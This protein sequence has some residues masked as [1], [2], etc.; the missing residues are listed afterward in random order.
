MS[1]VSASQSFRVAPRWTVSGQSSF[2]PRFAPVLKYG[3]NSDRWRAQVRLR[4]SRTY[5]PITLILWQKFLKSYITGH[6]QTIDDKSE[7]SHSCWTTMTSA[8]NF[9]VCTKT[10]P[11]WKKCHFW[12]GHRYLTRTLQKCT[13]FSR[14]HESRNMGIIFSFLMLELYQKDLDR[15]V[16]LSVRMTKMSHFKRFSWIIWLPSGQQV[17]HKEGKINCRILWRKKVSIAPPEQGV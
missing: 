16:A 12:S 2:K 4:H 11:Q 15:D 10:T 8:G 1:L 6:Y 14:N 5:K 7:R 13:N 17:K 3:R 9:A